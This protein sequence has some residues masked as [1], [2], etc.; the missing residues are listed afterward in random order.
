MHNPSFS[1]CWAGGGYPLALYDIIKIPEL[2]ITSVLKAAWASLQG[3]LC[4]LFLYMTVRNKQS[5]GLDW[6]VLGGITSSS[7]S[8]FLMILMVWCLCVCIQSEWIIH[9]DE[10]FV[11]HSKNPFCCSRDLLWSCLSCLCVDMNKSVWKSCSSLQPKLL[12]V[13]DFLR[14]RHTVTWQYLSNCLE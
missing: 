2:A 3:L 11:G 10:S 1:R 8:V 13:Q 7:V 6:D 5:A 12:K 9:K 4:W 14:L